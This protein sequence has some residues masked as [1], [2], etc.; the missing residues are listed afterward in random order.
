MNRKV[1]LYLGVLMVVLV[2]FGVSQLTAGKEE[3]IITADEMKKTIESRYAGE[4]ISI[5]LVEEGGKNRYSSMLQGANG[6]Y[7]IRTDAHSGQI[8]QLIPLKMKPADSTQ[9]EKP[10][11]PEKTPP[12]QANQNTGISLDQARAI[13]LE[14]IDGTFDGIEVEEV[15]GALAYEVEIDT[16]DHQEVKVQVDAYTGRVLSVVWED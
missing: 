3:E 1:G 5:E 9:T 11:E 6:I 2:V 15:N 12:K 13:A 14:Q 8:L 4:V 7:Q 10:A 16:A